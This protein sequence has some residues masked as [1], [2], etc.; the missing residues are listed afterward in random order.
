V[1]FNVRVRTGTPT[2]LIL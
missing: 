1:K 2:L